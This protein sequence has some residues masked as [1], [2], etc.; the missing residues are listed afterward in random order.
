MMMLQCRT[1]A[2]TAPLRA[3]VK[4][5]FF[6]ASL[7]S[8]RAAADSASDQLHRGVAR[9]PLTPPRPSNEDSSVFIKSFEC[10]EA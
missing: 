10:N 6:F 3:A 9:T 1:H 7:C 5:R 4:I 8:Y 2:H